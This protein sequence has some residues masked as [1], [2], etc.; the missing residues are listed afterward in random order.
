MHAAALLAGAAHRAARRPLPGG[1]APAPVYDANDNIT[2]KTAPN[3]AVGGAT[4]ATAGAA[5]VVSG[6]VGLNGDITALRNSDDGSSS[7]GSSGSGSSGSGLRTPSGSDG[8]PGNWTH[9][10]R[11]NPDAPWW[12]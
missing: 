6:A 1:A 11:P 4:L 5:A 2:Q 10:N 9:I 3:G 8:G 12:R 7:G